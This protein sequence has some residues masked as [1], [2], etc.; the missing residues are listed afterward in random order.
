MP[1]RTYLDEAIASGCFDPNGMGDVAD[2]SVLA[3]AS[4]GICGA[5]GG[6]VAVVCDVSAIARR[7]PFTVS[8]FMFFYCF[9]LRFQVRGQKQ[10]V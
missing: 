6:N 7:S 8:K 5:E 10:K 4:E 9:P 3:A 2:A 1:S